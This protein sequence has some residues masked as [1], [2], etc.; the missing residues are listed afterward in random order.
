[1]INVGFS[2]K[3]VWLAERVGEGKENEDN[4]WLDRVSVSI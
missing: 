3:G 4:V 2:E 1:M